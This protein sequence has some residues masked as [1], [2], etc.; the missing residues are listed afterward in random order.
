M[1][2]WP[3]GHAKT[4]CTTINYVSWLVGNYP[5]IHVTIVTKTSALAEA[6]LTALM[7]RIESDQSYKDIFN[8]LKPRDP[9]KWTTQKLI[10][11]R[12]EISKSPTIKATGLMGDITGGRSDI[13]ICDDLIDEEN[14]RTELQR[15]KVEAW[16]NKVL[17]PTLYP[18]G[19]L[20]VIGTRWHYADLYAHL[21]LQSNWTKSV[22]TAIL[23][24]EKGAE[25][26]QILWPEY[27]SL[28][29]LQERRMEIGSIYFQA[30]YM[31]N[32]TAM[33]GDLLKAEYL[34]PW[35]E[36][37]NSFN[38]P[39][40]LPVYAGIDPSLGESDYF[41]IASLSYDQMSKTAY[42]LDVW[43]QHLPFPQILKEKIP[44]LNSLYRYQ[45]IFMETNFW[46]KLL[47]KMPEL[48]GLP[49]V[50]VQTVKN[51][52]E[53]FI[54]LSSHFEAKRVL[55]NPLLLSSSNEFF[56]EWIQFPRGAHD[57]A[58][59]CVEMVVS[60]ILGSPSIPEGNCIAFPKP[61]EKLT[62]EERLQFMQ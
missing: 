60:N 21:L 57:D 29:R 51:K 36:T 39:N 2:L 59:D 33:Q 27:W 45:K 62:L 50:P 54:P 3:R 56:N 40:Y 58:L 49:I 61:P 11:N 38:P 48:Q 43:A 22:K 53:R 52:E 10:V 42:L 14:V 8:D 19:A 6:I 26:E 24:D 16:F 34:H 18:W 28:K 35:N 25:T 30:Q 15:E 1:Q 13:I 23:L 7:T 12:S 32:P 37:N 46:Q 17:L 47:L 5:N 55:V 4:E 31:N 20:I 44:Q 41:G 9:K